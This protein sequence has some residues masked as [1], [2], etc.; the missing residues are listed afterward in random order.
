MKKSQGKNGGRGRVVRLERRPRRAKRPPLRTLCG[1]DTA[2]NGLASAVA[3]VCDARLPEAT[4]LE[5]VAESC[6]YLEWLRASGVT[7]ELWSADGKVVALKPG[8]LPST[9]I[10]HVGL[11]STD[12][13]TVQAFW[14]MDEQAR[15][16]ALERRCPLGAGLLI[17]PVQEDSGPIERGAPVVAAMKARGERR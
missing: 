1:V 8:K 15:R 16:Q 9:P 4:R 2:G 6:W 11:R 14:Q 7:A 3:V 13:L 5:A 17:L 10:A 12:V